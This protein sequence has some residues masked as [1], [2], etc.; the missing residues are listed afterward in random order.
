MD[1]VMHEP[2]V[3]LEPVA[4]ERGTPGRR[5]GARTLWTA[6]N[7]ALGA[8]SGAAPHVL[9]HVGPLVG[10]ALVAGAG[11]TLLFGALGLAL[12]VPFLIRLHRRFSS[13]WAPA[14]ALLVFAGMF[15]LSTFVVGPRL[16]GAETPAPDVSPTEHTNHH[17]TA[18]D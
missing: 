12:S 13:W 4:P 3:A 14:V 15:A 5:S 8:V 17:G 16:S 18:P 7:G 9:H 6:L 2:V 1:P 11:G 10:T